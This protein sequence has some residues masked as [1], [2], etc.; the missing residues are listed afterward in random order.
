MDKINTSDWIDVYALAPPWTG[1]T[2][3]SFATGS[4]TIAPP[5]E[6]ALGAY[7]NA[8][9]TD[10]IYVVAGFADSNAALNTEASSSWVF[11]LRARLYF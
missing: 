11:G 10:D 5:D 8:M 1:F 9:L 2:N 7:F 4:A 3:F 6:A